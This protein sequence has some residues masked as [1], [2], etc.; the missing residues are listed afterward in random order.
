[1]AAMAA[2]RQLM[3]L[4]GVAAA[5]TA[6]AR[7]AVASAS[8]TRIQLPH[9]VVEVSPSGAIQSVVGVGKSGTQ[10]QLALVTETPA[11]LMVAYF[12]DAAAFPPYGAV[13]GTSAVTLNGTT[14]LA[15]F[16]VVHKRAREQE[17]KRAREI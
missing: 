14:L 11:T 17:S 12:G 10:R 2:L 13:V 4:V 16:K 15:T 7:S 9:L 5:A 3:L 8:P 1:M 6:A